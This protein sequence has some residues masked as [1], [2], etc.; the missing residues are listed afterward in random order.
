MDPKQEQAPTAVPDD[1][2]STVSRLATPHSEEWQ[3][4]FE[5]LSVRVA[6]LEQAL[7]AAERSRDLRS[8]VLARTAHELRTPLS[9]IFGLSQLLLDAEPDPARRESL[10]TISHAAGG[11]V[12]VVNDLLDL[13]TLEA[14]QL[15]LAREPFSIRDCIEDA[16]ELVAHDARAKRLDL[17]ALVAPDVPE[18][19]LGDPARLRQVLINLVHNAVK[20]TALGS[21]TVRA[22]SLE[23]SPERCLTCIEVTDTGTGLSE[24]ARQRLFN[25]FAHTDVD[26]TGGRGAGLGLWICRQLVESQGGSIAVESRTGRGS[27]FRVTLPLAATDPRPPVPA[28]LLDRRIAVIEAQLPARQSLVA[29]LGARGANVLSFAT[30]SEYRASAVGPELLIMGLTGRDLELDTW[31]ADLIHLRRRAA[32]PI[33]ILAPTTE[34]EFELTAGRLGATRILA[35]PVRTAA[36]SATS[37]DLISAARADA[38]TGARHGGGRALTVLLVE[39]DAVN[40]LYMKTLLEERAARVTV[41]RSGNE[42]LAAA[43]SGDPDLVVMDAHLL[44]M[45]GAE[46][47]R[48]LR[49]MPRHRTTPILALTADITERTRAL[50]EQAGVDLC[51]AKPIESKA[52]WAAAEQLLTRGRHDAGA[53][54]I[55][56]AEA[57]R[58]ANGSERKAARLLQTFV[59]ELPPYR[60]QIESAVATGACNTAADIAHALASAS[61]YCAT[62]ALH[63]VASRMEEHARA[64]DLTRLRATLP[65]LLDAIA[66]VLTSAARSDRD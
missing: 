49:A 48:Q 17:I 24:P 59:A 45:H 25:P 18:T 51:L 19:L 57:L 26:G 31:R 30:A 55:D 2:S 61:I 6:Y 29:A 44:D 39:D 21:V 65:E 53:A 41:A 7:A 60:Q 14:G 62:P 16:L 10:R 64:G 27:C 50:L 32:C 40:Q 23:N 38:S 37:K 4:S 28:P 43:L 54:V 42:A 47:T 66:A 15:R 11:L 33:L 20:F 3:R 35:R 9:G 56:R 8:E 46:V 12:N 22:H 52:F 1:P 63:A 34:A 58:R 36:L 13:A 5:A